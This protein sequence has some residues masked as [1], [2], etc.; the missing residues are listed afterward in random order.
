MELIRGHSSKFEL[1]GSSV[2]FHVKR[3]RSVPRGTSHWRVVDSYR[4]Q[5]GRRT[6][7][8]LRIVSRETF[9]R[10]ST[11]NITRA[12]CAFIPRPG[13]W[14]LGCSPSGAGSENIACRNVL[15]FTWNSRSARWKWNCRRGCRI[16]NTGSSFHVEHFQNSTPVFTAK[17]LFHVKHLASLRR[18]C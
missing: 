8:R 6:P 2:L 11:W 15:C 16:R 13:S 18:L 14:I 4:P 17:L 12:V 10:C 9:A 1:P 7:R 5:V 3:L